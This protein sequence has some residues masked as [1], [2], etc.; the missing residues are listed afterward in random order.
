MQ[1]NGVYKAIKRRTVAKQNIRYF[2][3]NDWIYD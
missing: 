1:I 2:I 3:K